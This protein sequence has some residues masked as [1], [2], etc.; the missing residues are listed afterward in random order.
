[1]WNDFHQAEVCRIFL[2]TGGLTSL[3]VY[4]SQCKKHLNN[5]L[6]ISNVQKNTQI[7]CTFLY[8]CTTWGVYTL[9]DTL[10]DTS[11]NSRKATKRHYGEI[12]VYQ[13]LM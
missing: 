12:V 4:I 1:M 10:Y 7:V 3:S 2:H 13:V 9:C 11:K 6:S 8:K 5:S